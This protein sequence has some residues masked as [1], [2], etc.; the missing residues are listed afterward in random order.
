MKLSTLIYEKKGRIAYIT[1]NRPERGNSHNSVMLKELPLVWKDFGGDDNL[2]VAILTG[3]GTRHFCT[4]AD[5]KDVNEVGLNQDM[6]ID[7]LGVT[8]RMCGIWKPVICAVNGA[9]CGGGLHSV[10]D[11][12]IVICS[13]N[14]TFFD[15]H[16]AVG[17]VAGI[18][19][20]AL[21]RK[22][23]S[24][25]VSYMFLMGKEV[26]LTAQ[27]ACELGLVNEVVPFDKLMPRATQI[28]EIILEKAPL[29]LR[30]TIEALWK[31]FDLGLHDAL[32]NAVNLIKLNW[33]TED[34]K[35][36]PRAFAEKRK[37]QWKA[38]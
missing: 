19:P 7:N 33:A 21:S 13:E 29:A 9:C 16:L 36:G 15:N 8:Q 38:R 6:R 31:G 22:I 34:F 12:D 35:E 2:W 20:V 4:G 32:N 11:A 23:P 17:M 37:P 28:A 24:G 26:R 27:R 30:A 5:V 10:T 3:A 18:E 1:L 25:L 14:A